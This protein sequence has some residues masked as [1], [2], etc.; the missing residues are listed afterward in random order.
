MEKT[1]S[2]TTECA[3]NAAYSALRDGSPLPEFSLQFE[4]FGD[5]FERGKALDVEVLEFLQGRIRLAEEG[6]LNVQVS[7]RG[8][9][10][11]GLAAMGA[12]IAAAFARF[13]LRENFAGATDDRRWY[14]G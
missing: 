3:E 5:G 9:V 1:R 12:V 11:H 7:G 2:S 6:E 8:G 4:E 10:A 14:S 13:E